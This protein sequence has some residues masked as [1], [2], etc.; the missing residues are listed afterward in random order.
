[1]AEYYRTVFSIEDG[2]QSGLGLLTGVEASVREWAKNLAGHPIGKSLGTWE[3]DSDSLTIIAQHGKNLGIFWMEWERTVPENDIGPWRLGVRLATEGKDLEADIE[4]NGVEGAFRSDFGAAP[5]D[6][7]HTLFSQF[8]CSVNDRRLLTASQRVRVADAP[9]LVA[10]ILNPGRNMP[11]IVVSEDSR[12]LVAIDADLLQSR[13]LG[14]AVVYTYDHDVAWQFSKDLPRS[15]RCYDGALRL[16][17]PNCTV[18]D[19]PQQHPY[20]EP[21]DVERLSQERTISV[22][23]DECVNRL[24]RRGR[25]RLFSQ[26]RNALR[27][28]EVR[29]LEEYIETLENQR[30][31]DE[32]LLATTIGELIDDIGDDDEMS[33]GRYNARGRVARVYRNMA[34]L[35][36]EENRQLKEEIEQLE[37]SQ[38]EGAPLQSEI[39]A[40]QHEVS[41]TQPELQDSLLEGDEARPDVLQVVERARAELNGLRFFES[42][43]DS[44]RTATQG[45]HFS[46]TD[47]LFD[48]FKW[49]SKCAER[50]RS[51]L[52]MRLEDWFSLRGVSY[53]RH[54]SETTA[55]QHGDARKFRDD[56][57]DSYVSMPAHFKLRDS[58]FHLRVHVSWESKDDMW[59]VGYVGAHLP[60]STDPH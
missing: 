10:E 45:G 14:L 7:V 16:F 42:A 33:V 22:L 19:V 4:V 59:L 5:P 21:S 44:A 31:D 17:S 9:A 30:S 24:P 25:R 28:E 13:L 49:M 51:G 18:E 48:V 23:S 35:L 8:N 36:K 34:D 54:E 29:D 52:G 37:R 12:E 3:G 50:R 38:R 6:I 58:G 57:S 32:P 55:A 39:Q 56:A 40:T 26:V 1:M 2:E 60:T 27:S 41:E 15:L 20:W 47:E 43:L 11:L 53:S 46:T